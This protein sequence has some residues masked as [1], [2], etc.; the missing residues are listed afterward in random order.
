MIVTVSRRNL[1]ECN[2]NS[3]QIP[4]TNM[5]SE[6][7]AAI[8]QFYLASLTLTLLPSNKLLQTIDIDLILA[9]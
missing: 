7:K 1:L 5:N 4:E 2:G 6:E 3:W 8:K 9:R